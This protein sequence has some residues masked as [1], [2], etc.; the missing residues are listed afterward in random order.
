MRTAIA[1]FFSLSLLGGCVTVYSETEVNHYPS[2]MQEKHPRGETVFA[3]TTVAGVYEY[4]ENG[5]LSAGCGNVEMTAARYRSRFETYDGERFS[6]IEFRHGFET[7]YTF[8][9]RRSRR[10]MYIY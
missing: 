1:L 5:G 4:L 2:R 8:E 10:R 6:I 7:Y 9:E 3:C